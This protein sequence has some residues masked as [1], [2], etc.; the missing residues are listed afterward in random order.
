M[1]VSQGPADATLYLS[2]ALAIGEAPRFDA[3]LQSPE[4]LAGDAMNRARVILLNDVR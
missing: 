4:A 3:T 2:R 1:T